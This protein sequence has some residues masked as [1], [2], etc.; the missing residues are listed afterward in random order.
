MNGVSATEFAPD[1]TLSRAMAVTMLYRM[2]GEPAAAAGALFDDVAAGKWYTDAVLW[3]SDQGIADGY[4]NGRF[5][6]NDNITRQQLAVILYR[7]AQSKG[8]GFAGAWMFPLDYPDASEVSGWA[9][10]A[11]HWM[12]MNGVISGK[13]GKLAPKDTLTRAEMAVILKTF[14]TLP[15]EEAE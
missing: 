11:M 6:P 12:V 8:Q 14:N 7:Y 3:A 1:S 9:D 10:E 13:D 2:E 15:A 5:G 4:G